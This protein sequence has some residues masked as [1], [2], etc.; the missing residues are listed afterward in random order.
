MTI[1]AAALSPSQRTEI[2]RACERLCLDYAHYADTGQSD[3]WA[4][5]FAEDGQMRLFGKEHVGRAAIRASSS[6]GG[7]NTTV[8]SLS[9]IRIEAISADE[10]RGTNYVTVYSQDKAAPSSASLVPVLVGI[11]RDDYRRTAE[12]WRI[13]RR[14]FQPL[15]KPVSA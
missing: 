6:G 2:E 13:A 4:N 11:Y 14:A 12:G 15:I 7:P 9:N 5:L 1:A 8:H 10:A 3:D